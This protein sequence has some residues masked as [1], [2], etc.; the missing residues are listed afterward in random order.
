VDINVENN[1][2]A[3][4]LFSTIGN[5][6]TASSQFEQQLKHFKLNEALRTSI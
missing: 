6:K 5:R 3:G 1:V 2:D 4:L